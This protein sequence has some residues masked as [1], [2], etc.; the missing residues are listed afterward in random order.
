MKHPKNDHFSERRWD[1]NP[2]PH[3]ITSS[4]LL[5]RRAACCTRKTTQTMKLLGRRVRAG[6]SGS[7]QLLPQ[8]EEDMWHL[9]NVL[10]NGDK[11]TAVTFR[12]TQATSSTGE[13]TPAP[14]P[15]VRALSCVRNLFFALFPPLTH[16]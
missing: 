9:Y 7:I 12:K 15:P 8:E 2:T 1:G 11:L 6:D 4:T 3:S 13:C 10:A 16:L 14:T 5:L